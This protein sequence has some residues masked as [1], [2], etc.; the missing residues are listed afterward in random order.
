MVSAGFLNHQQYHLFSSPN[1][2]ETITPETSW[3]RL[4][5]PLLLRCL[6]QPSPNDP[7]RWRLS[8]VPSKKQTKWGKKKHPFYKHLNL[9]QKKWRWWQPRNWSVTLPLDGDSGDSRD[10]LVKDSGCQLPKF[11]RTNEALSAE[12]QLLHFHL[13][14]IPSCLWL[15]A[16]DLEL[17]QTCSHLPPGIWGFQPE[18]STQ[19]WI[20]LITTC[21]SDIC[22]ETTQILQMTYSCMEYTHRIYS[23]IY[24]LFWVTAGTS[25]YD[26]QLP[27]NSAPSH[28]AGPTRR[29]WGNESPIYQ[30]VKVEGPSFPTGSLRTLLRLRGR[31]HHCLGA[32]KAVRYDFLHLCCDLWCLQFVMYVWHVW[33]MLCWF[34]NCRYMKM[35]YDPIIFV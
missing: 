29:E 13:L 4:A 8:T 27:A 23:H 33:C 10:I 35:L 3:H 5:A 18:G 31:F 12:S 19:T 30:P 14:P 6:S 15:L 24:G 32:I 2:Q 21:I 1:H 20:L 17:C 26:C 16:I 25:G 9:L 22:C 11:L 28:L 34:M 7:F